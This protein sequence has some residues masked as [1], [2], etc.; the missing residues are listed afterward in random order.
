MEGWLQTVVG[1]YQAGFRRGRRIAEHIMAIKVLAQQGRA[2]ATRTFACFIDLQSAYDLVPRD[3]LFRI[4]EAYGLPNT[5]I[6]IIRSVY[7]SAEFCVRIGVGATGAKSGSFRSQRGLLQRSV[8]SPVL[9]NVF[10]QAV[11]DEVT[12]RLEVAGI[13]GGVTRV[14]HDGKELKWPPAGTRHVTYW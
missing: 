2:G 11:I 8:L 4:L 6:Q 1:R 10:L 3:L 9:F 7:R 12:W 5:I 14:R 13:T